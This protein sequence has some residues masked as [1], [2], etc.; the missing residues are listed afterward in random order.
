MRLP[1]GCV[2]VFLA[3]CLIVSAVAC[4]RGDN[5]T[6]FA[7]LLLA[8]LNAALNLVILL[9]RRAGVIKRRCPR[10]GAVV[11]W[12]ANTCPGCFEPL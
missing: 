9:L 2:I 3:A 8:V 10:C 7:F 6:A 4:S 11:P 1:C 5:E 12:R